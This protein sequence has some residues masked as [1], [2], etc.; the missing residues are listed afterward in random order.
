MISTRICILWETAL[1]A[2]Q[3]QL[4]NLIL[5]LDRNRNIILGDTEDLIQLNP[6]DSKWEAFGWECHN[7]DG[8]SVEELLAV[9]K[10]VNN[11]NGKPKII[12]A[13]TIK[14]K[15]SSI[16]EHKPDWHYWQGLSEEQIELTRKELREV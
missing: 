6:I 8:H 15:G 5:I 7:V 9:F 10:K 11:K 3:Y 13:N 4:D 1:F 2:A 12:I 14:G 16:M